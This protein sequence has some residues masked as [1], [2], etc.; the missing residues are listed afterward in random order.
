MVGIDDEN[1]GGGRRSLDGGWNRLG[2]AG[3]RSRSWDRPRRTAPSDAAAIELQAEAAVGPEA[4]Q[5]G[6]VVVAERAKKKQA[7]K[8]SRKNEPATLNLTDGTIQAQGIE[9]GT[10]EGELSPLPV[11]YRLVT[12]RLIQSKPRKSRSKHARV[13]YKRARISRRKLW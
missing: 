8:S 10:G 5:G 4:V 3:G 7:G 12:L 2:R 6:G 9:G 11:R 1:N 13:S